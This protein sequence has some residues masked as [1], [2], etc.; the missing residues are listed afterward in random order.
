MKNMSEE[1]KRILEMVE[2]GTISAQEALTLLEALE[3][4]QAS[5]QDQ[6]KQI[7]NELVTSVHEEKGEE[8]SKDSFYSS[9]KPKDKVMDFVNSAL[10]KIK[11]FDFDFQWK[12]SV[13]LSHVFQQADVH[14]DKIDMDV[15]N[16][17]V[18]IIPWDQQDVRLECQAKVYRTEDR[19]EARKQFLENTSFVVENAGLFYSTQLKWMKV[20]TKV[21]V[22]KQYYKK[23]SIRQFNGGLK[24]ENISVEEFKSKTANGKV[25]I[26]HITS[27]KAEI[28]TSNGAIQLLDV[29]ADNLDAESI[30]GKIE[31]EGDIR[32]SDVQ[33]LNGNIVCKLTGENADTI[34]SKAV[35]GNIDIYVPDGHAVVGEAKSNLGGFKVELEGIN[36]VEE[37]N[38]IV[39][40]HIRF[41][42]NPEADKKLHIFAET[43]SGSVLIK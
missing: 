3:K 39:Q 38:D 11:N 25:F 16:G 32:Y 41:S 17:K 19:E 23:I 9:S 1:R 8:N 20:D 13:E 27:E 40:K 34:H 2:K 35:T 37:K 15:A 7:F 43:K 28:E 29:K 22:P 42:K 14:L 4:K 24:A 18:E 30:N 31:V 12:H 36:V 21:Y 33:S 6:E 10:N 26:Q 5:Q